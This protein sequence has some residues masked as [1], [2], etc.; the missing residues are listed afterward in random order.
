MAKAVAKTTLK[1]NNDEARSIAK[2]DFQY[3]HR[4]MNFTEGEAQFLHGHSGYIEIEIAGNVD[5]R[6]GF[7]Y[8]CKEAV[9]LIKEVSDNFH[10][11]IIFQEGD[12]IIEHLLAGYEAAGIRNGAS[13]VD[14]VRPKKLNHPLVRSHP[15]CRVTITKKVTTCENFCEIF[16]ELLKDKLNIKKITFRSSSLNA[17]TRY[18]E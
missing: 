4:F 7:A 14:A 2:W 11:S 15:E 6:T 5:A 17:A 3:A 16:Y 12:P 8:P 10:H 13:R 9:K 1:T 18:Y